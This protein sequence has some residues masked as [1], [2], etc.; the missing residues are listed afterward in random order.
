MLL[1]A[2]SVTAAEEPQKNVQVLKGLSAHELQRTMNIM[3]AGL[4]LHCDFS[5]RRPRRLGRDRAR[6]A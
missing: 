5:A 1:L 3:R 2:P 4:G 6:R